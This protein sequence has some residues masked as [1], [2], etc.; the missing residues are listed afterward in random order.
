MLPYHV[1]ACWPRL[2][3]QVFL[4]FS[5]VTDTLHFHPAQQIKHTVTNGYYVD[6]IA[7]VDTPLTEPV[8]GGVIQGFTFSV[9]QFICIPGTVFPI[10][11]EVAWH[12]GPHMQLIYL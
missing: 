1:V 7:C 3:L 4:R 10:I 6:E 9:F 12:S 11:S 5:F 8:T 2:P